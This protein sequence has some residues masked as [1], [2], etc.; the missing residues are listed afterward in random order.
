MQG[1]INWK[2]GT[3]SDTQTYNVIYHD[4]L[5]REHCL[6]FAWFSKIWRYG[7]DGDPFLKGLVVYYGRPEIITEEQVVFFTTKTTYELLEI[8]RR[9]LNYWIRDGK[10]HGKRDPSGN[11]WLFPLSEINRLRVERGLLAL[12]KS[13]ANVFW[14]AQVMK[15]GRPQHE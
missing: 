11:R 12:T 7:D 14:K 1:S 2:T 4:S 8:K 9:N 13:E 15:R 6:D 5:S 3:P 10:I